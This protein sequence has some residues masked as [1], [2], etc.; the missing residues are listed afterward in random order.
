MTI[1]LYS[2]LKGVVV[3]EAPDEA[4]LRKITAKGVYELINHYFPKNEQ[5][6][7]STFFGLD[8]I[9]YS[10]IYRLDSLEEI[11]VEFEFKDG[12]IIP[13]VPLCGTSEDQSHIAMREILSQ[14]SSLLEKRKNKYFMITNQS[15]CCP[16]RSGKVEI[17]ISE[18]ERRLK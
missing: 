2:G 14:A 4:V 5:G 1:C 7:V 12:L 9:G 17:T 10:K 13:K 6:I 11:P 3:D 16:F 15:G 18:F 8:L